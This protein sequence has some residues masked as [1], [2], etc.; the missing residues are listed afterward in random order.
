[1][2]N[3]ISQRLLKEPLFTV[4]LDKYG[5]QPSFYTFGYIDETVLPAGS[6]IAYVNVDSSNGFWEFPSTQMKIGK[7]TVKRPTGNTAIADTGTTVC[8]TVLDTK[9]SSL[10]G[11]LM[12]LVDFG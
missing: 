8:G 3:L 11:L 12:P 2:E 1:M 10:I 9:N 5:D 4:W 7:K 6:H